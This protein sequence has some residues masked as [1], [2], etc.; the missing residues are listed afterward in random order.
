[1]I[2]LNIPITSLPLMIH[3]NIPITSLPLMNIPNYK[4]AP[5]DPL[6]YPQLQVCP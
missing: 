2:H 1:M 3:L 5:N 6:E 4:S